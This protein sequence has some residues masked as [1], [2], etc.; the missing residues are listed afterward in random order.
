MERKTAW[1]ILNMISGI[2]PVSIRKLIEVYRDPVEILN[3]KPETVRDI[4]NSSAIEGL[5]NWKNIQWEK[6]IEKA[7]SSGIKIVTF[8]EPCYPESLKQIPDPPP[9]LYVKGNIPE[10][11]IFIAV[12]GTRNPS[13][14]GTSMAE[15]FSLE[16]ASYGF[17]IVSGL[18]RGID[19]IAHRAALKTKNQTVA[20]LGSGL[21]NIYP[22]ENAKL[23]EEISQN[24]AIISEFP[25][26][27]SPE[28]FNFPRRNRIISGL[29][30]A[31][32]VIE[33]GQ[34][35]GALITAHL[36]AEQNK[37]VFV[38]P[39]DVNR[40]TGKGNNQLIKDGAT[41]VE[42]VEEILK[43]LNLELITE[44]SD[45]SKQ[46]FLTSQVLT[47]NEKLVYN[48]IKG[49][50]VDFETIINKTCISA[51]KLMQILTGLEIKGFIDF[52]PGSIYRDKKSDN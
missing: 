39:S 28:K 31:V 36:A 21:A 23:A 51:D 15:K 27:T 14:Y 18:A 38:L 20:V 44:Q 40:I 7:E 43:E 52:L 47:E 12:V 5:K 48:V 29:S 11:R 16:L 45:D 8:D 24:G 3:T 32:L 37:E 50:S 13:F 30:R 1:I 42:S 41:L 22:A 35:S 34:R 19:S 49:K 6:E 26:D 4:I 33:A 25:L 2:G 9:V 10:N 17:C 46:D